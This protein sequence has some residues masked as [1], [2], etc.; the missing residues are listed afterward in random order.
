[1]KGDILVTSVYNCARCHK[2]HKKLEFHEFT[3]PVED[4]DGT[5]WT[6]WVLC[7]FSEEPILLKVVEEEQP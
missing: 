4:S 6:H 3:F 5:K 1:M 2:D 7:P